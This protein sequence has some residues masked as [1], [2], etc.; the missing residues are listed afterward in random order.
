MTVAV[1][2]L[3]LD[4]QRPDQ[5]GLSHRSSEPRGIGRM[6]AERPTQESMLQL[7]GD[8]HAPA[9]ATRPMTALRRPSVTQCRNS[10]GSADRAA[11]ASTRTRK[12]DL[13]LQPGIQD[14]L[15]VQIALMV[16]A[17][18]R[19]G[20]R[21]SF[22]LIDKNSGARIRLHARGRG[23]AHHAGRDST[24]DRLPQPEARLAARNPLL[25]RALARLHP[26][27]GRAEARRRRRVDDADPQHARANERCGT[28]QPGATPSAASRRAGPCT[29]R[30]DPCTRSRRPRRDSKNSICATPSLA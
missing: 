24:R 18:A 4:Q 15:S 30:R 11:R 22:L 23:N 9:A 6:F 1:S 27:A 25:V 10:I 16:R 17:A 13:P 2:T 5:L 29:C 19:A 28:A 26:A 12:V 8:R 3:Q 21:S 20:R 14:D 7:T